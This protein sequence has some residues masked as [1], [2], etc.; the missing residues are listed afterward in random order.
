[1]VFREWELTADR[2]DSG[3][4]NCKA[5]TFIGAGRVMSLPSWA[6]LSNKGTLKTKKCRHQ[7]KKEKVARVSKQASY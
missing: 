6:V 1:M 7:K 5:L 4:Q 3:Q 2:P